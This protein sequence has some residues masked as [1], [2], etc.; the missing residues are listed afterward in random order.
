MAH[1]HIFTAMVRYSRYTYELIDRAQDFT[2][3][4]PLNNCMEKQLRICG[5]KYVRDIDKFKEC[6]LE[7]RS[8]E[9]VNSSIIDN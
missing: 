2:V 3:S 4:F 8:G 7:L 1:M 9:K 6:K 5:A